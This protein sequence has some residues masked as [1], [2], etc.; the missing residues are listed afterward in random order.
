ML[1]TGDVANAGSSP[2]WS[3]MRKTEV[4][5]ACMPAVVPLAPRVTE[6][7]APDIVPPLATAALDTALPKNAKLNN[8]PDPLPP[9]TL[10]T[11]PRNG[12]EGGGQV[13]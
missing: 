10:T 1:T 11:T 12:L 3:D 13:E 6:S 4:A 8:A 5:A 2:R 9:L 7:I